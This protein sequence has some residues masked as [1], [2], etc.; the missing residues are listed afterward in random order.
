M[1]PFPSIPRS[2]DA[3]ADLFE[4]GH[5][6]L[7][8]H[9]VGDYLRFRLQPAGGLQFGDRTR[10]FDGETPPPY[11]HAVDHVREKLDRERLRLAVDDPGSVVFYGVAMHAAGVDYDWERTPSFLGVDVWSG[12]REQFRPPDAAEQIF[13]QLGL[14]PVNAVEKERNARDFDPESYT[15]SE[16]A[17][18]DGPAAGVLLVNKRGGRAVI[19]NP[20]VDTDRSVN[21]VE[22]S[23]E[24]VAR[25]FAPDARFERLAAR[26]D[27][28]GR[29]VAF[30]PLYDLALETVLR[31]HHDRLT[32][33]QSSVALGEFR[34]ALA[35]RT[36][37]Y[38][39]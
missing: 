4:T 11:E 10:V 18:Y 7:L 25:E 20:A 32:H 19:E 3:P 28:E 1:H 36:R 24:A 37:A 9:V 26:L 17:W 2:A 29:P 30:Q 31:A 15:V 14:H 12:D 16:S 8:E 38:L 6:W 34:G 21:P 23:P 39:E 5:L 35:A 13:E 27:A 33:S 22:G